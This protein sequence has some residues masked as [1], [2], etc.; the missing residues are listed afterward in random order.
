MGA[1]VWRDGGE[2][3]G[4]QASTRGAFVDILVFLCLDFSYLVCEPLIAFHS[5]KSSSDT[6]L[7]QIFRAG[8]GAVYTMMTLVNN[9][10]CISSFDHFFWFCSRQG[11]FA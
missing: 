3:T 1:F 2:G 10:L 4:G 7:L 6:R 5:P 8:Y 9:R 11:R